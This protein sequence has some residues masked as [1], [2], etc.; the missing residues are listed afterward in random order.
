M[1]NNKNMIG[2]YLRKICLLPPA[3]KP[4]DWISNHMRNRYNNNAR[5]TRDGAQP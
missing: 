5:L 2:Y 4:F 1:N 3:R